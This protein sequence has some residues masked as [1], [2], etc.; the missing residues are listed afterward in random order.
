MG[1]NFWRNGRVAGKT[2]RVLDAAGGP[3]DRATRVLRV[4]ARPG[5]DLRW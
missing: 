2:R 4:N 5:R 3:K 1:H